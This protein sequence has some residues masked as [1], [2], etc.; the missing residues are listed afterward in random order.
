MGLG[1][2]GRGLLS[3][4]Q[5]REVIFLLSKRRNPVKG[6]VGE[7]LTSD[8]DGGMVAYDVFVCFQMR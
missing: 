8:G 5:T 3:T 7:H 4:K 2:V 1:R 6:N